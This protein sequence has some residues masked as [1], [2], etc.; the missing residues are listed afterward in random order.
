MPCTVLLYFLI[1]Q[2]QCHNVALRDGATSVTSCVDSSHLF[3]ATGTGGPARDGASS[4][5]SSTTLCIAM[6]LSLPV[7]IRPPVAILPAT[8]RCKGGSNLS[9]GLLTSP[10]QQTPTDGPGPVNVRGIANAN[11]CW[12][13]FVPF[14][15][16][17][18]FP[19]VDYADHGVNPRLSRDDGLACP[20]NAMIRPLIVWCRPGVR[21]R[22]MRRRA[23][24][25][26]ARAAVWF[27]CGFGHK[28]HHEDLRCSSSEQGESGGYR[29]ALVGLCARLAPL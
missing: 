23:F 5:L 15:C 11:H 10:A 22:S 29:G 18:Q 25:F 20:L 4:W 3:P 1:R 24:S 19:A 21:S 12:G 16:S 9:E 14:T 2:N 26:H 27:A 28:I 13:S 7:P 8:L 6:L 17:A